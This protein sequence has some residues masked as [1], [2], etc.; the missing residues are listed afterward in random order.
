[1]DLADIQ[2]RRTGSRP[3]EELLLAA[4]LNEYGE[5]AGQAV[6]NHDTLSSIVL[7][8]EVY[9]LHGYWGDA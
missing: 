4:I 6:H 8:S 2:L 5:F 1:M 3:D 9:P 7:K